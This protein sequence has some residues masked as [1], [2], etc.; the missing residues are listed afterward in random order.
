MNFSKMDHITAMFYTASR[1][2]YTLATLLLL[3]SSVANSVT[4]VVDNRCTLEDAL[5]ASHEDA[6][7]GACR[8]GSGVDTIVLP[9][10]GHYVIPTQD[11]VE[12]GRRHSD[13][14]STVKS[15]VI[16]RGRRPELKLPQSKNDDVQ[17][18]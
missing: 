2:K 13:D 4:I 16:I 6:Q 12:T 17:L 18:T 11:E 9:A 5:R 3:G 14:P 15:T 10:D 1:I 8:A 7:I